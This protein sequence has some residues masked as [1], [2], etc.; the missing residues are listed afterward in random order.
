[1]TADFFRSLEVPTWLLNTYV[2]NMPLIQLW[3]ARTKWNMDL[4]FSSKND[5]EKWSR[6]I[7]FE[8]PPCAKPFLENLFYFIERGIFASNCKFSN[9]NDLL[10]TWRDFNEIFCDV[11]KYHKQNFKAKKS[12]HIPFWVCKQS[13]NLWHIRC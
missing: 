1:M 4:I 7:Y 11:F 8:I 6:K 3:C 2:L 12:T 10:C 5:D 9:K 13:M